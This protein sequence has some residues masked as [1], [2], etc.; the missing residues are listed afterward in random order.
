MKIFSEKLN[1]LKFIMLLSFCIIEILCFLMFFILYKPIYLKIFEQMSE[2]S[3]IK[4]ESIAK[5]VYEIIH[6]IFIKYTQD[7]KFIA[8]HMS[9]LANDEINIESDYYQNLMNDE[10]KHIYDANLEKLKKYFPEYYDDSQQKFLYL[11]NYINYYIENKTN[12]MNVLND[13]MNNAKHPELNSISFYKSEGNTSDIEKGSKKEIAA[14]YLI[15]VLKTVYINKFITKGRDFDINCFFLLTEDEL[16]IYPPDAFNNTLI[17]TFKDFCYNH[18]DIFP[19]C[20][21]EMINFQMYIW[22]LFH[23]DEDYIYPMFPFPF[24]EED[25]YY[26]T[27]CLSV[28]FEEPLVY[29]DYSYAPKICMELNMT[30]VFSRGFFESKELFHFLFFSIINEDIAIL[31]SDRFEIFSEIRKVFNNSIY[32][33][34]YYKY[35]YEEEDI[36]Y[37]YFFQILYL[38]LFK[39]P[40]LLKNNNITLNDIFQEYDIIKNKIM[41][42]MDNYNKIINGDYFYFNI[43]KTTCKSDIYYNNKKCLKDNFLIVIHPFNND[44]N[45]MDENYIEYPDE[46]INHD[47]FFSMTILD[48]NYDYFKWKI[49]KIILILI[50]KLF[51]FFFISSVCLYFLYFIFIQIFLEIKYNPINQILNIIKG[52]SLF[53]IT[54]KNE[55]AQKKREIL[56]K[57]NNKEILEIKNFFDYLLKT[58]LLKMN[59]EENEFN[60]KQNNKIKIPNNDS[61]NNKILSLDNVNAL[62]YYIL[63][64]FQKRIA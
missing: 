51:L 7:L 13:L 18:G 4:T 59:L 26:E 40:S 50:I 55:I 36:Q 57:A 21:L 41:Q 15:S 30:K 37:F 39:E 5:S 44:F 32:Q 17:S 19:S 27:E 45:V 12:Q 43:E 54:N 61:I 42:E 8:K 9:F 1:K 53:E 6:L 22:T 63:Y 64:L 62:F 48:N 33:K 23:Y 11:E 2:A 56:I 20:I 47:I 25:K 35:E 60:S 16:Y 31:F 52:G 24:F 49:N 28:P 14:K 34:Y 38:D 3:I 10:D 29:E 58:I 46:K